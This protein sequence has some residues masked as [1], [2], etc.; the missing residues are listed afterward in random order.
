MKHILAITTLL[1]ASL[2]TLHAADW[3]AFQRDG[4]VEHP[5]TSQKQAQV[6]QNLDELWADFP[7]LDR[8]TPLEAE[9]LKE[10]NEG[11][12]VCRVV[13]FQ[14]G[15]FKG[16]P[17]RVAA[18]YAFPKGG[19]KLPALLQL[20]GGGQSANLDSVVTDARRGYAALSLNWGGNKLN[21]GRSTMIYDGPQTDWGKLDATHPPQRNKVNHFAGPLTPDEFTLDSVESPRNSNWFLVLMAARG[22][23]RFSSSSPRSIPRA[24]ASTDTRWA[25]SSPPTWPASSR[26]SKPPCRPAAVAAIFWKARR[27]CPAA[28]RSRPPRWNS[29]AS[30]TT[31]TSRASPAR[32]SGS[33]PRTISTPR[34][35]TWPGTG[36]I[37]PTSA[38][39]SAS[40]R[41]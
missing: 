26:A 13:R 29:P 20:H 17:S 1:L 21:F 31:P 22:R 23:S 12:V 34:S 41:I 16:A 15:I 37:C 5:G 35:A 14:V 38:P 7:R 40:R 11:D 8:D 9:T 4:E 24:S 27:T 2:A 30:P 39:A 32:S 10:W 6:P 25:A 3:Q 33:R 28:S 36:E 18:F 19:A